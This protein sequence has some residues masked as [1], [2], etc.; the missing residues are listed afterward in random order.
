VCDYHRLS[1]N[2]STKTAMPSKRCP[3]QEVC[4][5]VL[6][7]GRTY[8]APHLNI[9]TFMFRLTKLHLPNWCGGGAN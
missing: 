8:Y 9:S 2:G 6:G 3:E 1:W 4:V 7:N 5:I